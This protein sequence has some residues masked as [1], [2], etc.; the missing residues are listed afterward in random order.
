MWHV[1]GWIIAVVAAVL[2]WGCGSEQDKMERGAVV[3]REVAAPESDREME[4]TEAERRKAEMYEE[5][6]REN[7]LFEEAEK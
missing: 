6:D 4:M 3:D 7:E 5:E 2:L 1:S